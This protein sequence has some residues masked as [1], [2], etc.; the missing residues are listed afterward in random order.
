MSTSL[1]SVLLKSVQNPR[2]YVQRL[3]LL[4]VLRGKHSGR[5]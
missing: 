3:T 4:A 5:E 2:W 1:H